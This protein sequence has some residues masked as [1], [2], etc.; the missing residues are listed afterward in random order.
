MEATDMSRALLVDH[1]HDGQK[2]HRGNACILIENGKISRIFSFNNTEDLRIG[3]GEDCDAVD[4]RG[5]LVTPGLV[6]SHNHFTL[7]A[8][9]MHFQVDLGNARSFSGMK[10]LMLKK[11]PIE[12]SWMLGYNLN[13]FT[14]KEERLPTV[15]E[16]DEISTESPIAISHSSEHS[17]ICNSKALQL[18][19]LTPGTI[20]P[21]GSAIGR[22]A[23]GHPN[24]I[25]YETAAMNLV[26]SRIPEYTLDDYVEALFH[27]SVEYRRNGLT[28]VKD[29]GGT[30][31]DINEERRIQAL[32]LLSETGD[33]QV[34]VG[35]SIP[36]YSLSDIEYKI[37]LSGKV[38]ESD[39]IKF[40]GFKVFLDGAGLQRTGWMRQEWYRDYVHKDEG[41]FGIRL[42]DLEDFSRAL[43]MLASVGPTVSIHTI[44]DR[45]VSEAISIV[46]K[47]KNEGKTKS[48]FAFVHANTPDPDDI[49]KLRELGISIET[50]PSDMY[51]LGHV[52]LG[53]VGPV[54]GERIFP[55][56]TMLDSGVNVCNSSDS[57]V[58]RYEPIYG[59]LSSIRREMKQRPGYNAEYNPEEKLSLEETL[60]TYTSNGAR[61]MRWP[62][63][64]RIREGC[65][66]DMIS[67]RRMPEG[68]DEDLSSDAIFQRI[69]FS[70][71]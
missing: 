70:G 53:N 54:R 50:Q 61:V 64:G 22:F 65:F 38:N 37:G 5:K 51:F 7:T 41:N 6:D 13:E 40:T 9:K 3:I 20:V 66:A 21:P 17:L 29:T 43:S 18:S 47:L 23:D 62:E 24:G 31:N 68:F 58:M 52:Y 11:Y 4:F 48:E 15:R 26:K 39:L 8:L 32:N 60:T 12:G 69:I 34:R 28:A 2:F 1:Y 63:I 57:P 44:G 59:I 30:G 35:I 49:G 36:V 10:E 19:N 27:A 33:L 14:L 67:W 42:W 45:A 55:L 71:N 56:R 25:L 16:L 46:G